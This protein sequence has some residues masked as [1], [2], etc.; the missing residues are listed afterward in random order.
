MVPM[1]APDRPGA[2]AVSIWRRGLLC[3]ASVLAAAVVAELV[4][5]A[6][7]PRWLAVGMS[8]FTLAVVSSTVWMTPI[9]R[10]TWWSAAVRARQ[11]RSAEN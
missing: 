2:A 8:T 9:R 5:I 10:Q 3:L 1:P 7:G 6:D 11:R 4:T